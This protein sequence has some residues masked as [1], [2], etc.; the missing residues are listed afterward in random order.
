MSA[1]QSIE[2]VLLKSPG[3]STV[4][5]MPMNAIEDMQQEPHDPKVR[6]FEQ[7]RRELV[8]V[9]SKNISAIVV[10]CERALG[11]SFRTTDPIRNAVME[12]VER[13]AKVA[14][15]ATKVLLEQ[16]MWEC[17][18]HIQNMG[19]DE[20]DDIEEGVI[21]ILKVAGL[22]QTNQLETCLNEKMSD[23]DSLQIVGDMVGCASGDLVEQEL[24]SHI[25]QL[26]KQPDEGSA[27]NG[28]HNGHLS[29]GHLESP[30]VLVVTAK[31]KFPNEE[32]GDYRC[33]QLSSV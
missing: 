21:E 10:E 4:A 23:R 26:C 11:V 14:K 17:E 3:K 12:S 25:A 13:Q 15:E 6:F 32:F 31:Q 27:L 5:D 9:A 24:R 22:T 28:N 18:E 16:F 19:V 8:K 2:E 33:V 30:L 1:E 7:K 29:F 20:R